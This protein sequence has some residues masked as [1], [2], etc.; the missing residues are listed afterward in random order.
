M[1]RT[2]TR[3]VWLVAAILI[4][5][6]IALA[7]PYRY[8]V[9]EMPVTGT[10]NGSGAYSVNRDGSVVGYMWEGSLGRA[11]VWNPISNNSHVGTQSM[12]NQVG[13]GTMSAASS[14]SSNAK[15]AG[16]A[17]DASGQWFLTTWDKAT[18]N[19]SPLVPIV[20]SS[21]HALGINNAGQITYNSAGSPYVYDNGTSIL[22]SCSW[23]GNAAINQAGDVVGGSNNGLLGSYQ[24]TFWEA[25]NYGVSNNVGMLFGGGFVDSGGL[26]AINDQRRTTGYVV[27]DGKTRAYYWDVWVGSPTFILPPSVYSSGW[28]LNDQGDVVGSY[29][30]PQ[31]H[32]GKPFLFEDGVFIDLQS[33]IDPL[34]G[35]YLQEAFDINEFGQICGF[36]YLNGRPRGY[37]LT[38]IPTNQPP[39]ATNDFYGVDQLGTLNEPAPGILVNDSDPENDGLTVEL[40]AGPSHASS[41]Q[42][43]ANGSFTYTPTATFFGTDTYT[44]RVFDGTTYSDPATVTITVRQPGAQGFIT[45]GGKFFQ[46]GNKCTFGFVAKVQGNGVQGNLEFQDHGMGLNVKS[47]S[48]GWVYAPN[49][50]DG[51]FSGTCSVNGTPGYSYFVQIRDRGEPGRNDDLSV[52]LFDAA[53]VQVYSSSGT[54]S[55]GGNIQIHGS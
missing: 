40:L 1:R 20:V 51:Y 29:Q 53:G 36:G 49:L 4:P 17:R 25:G 34:S 50:I 12:L 48:V 52:W 43:N 8:Y 24:G 5:A 18:G 14:I 22:L 23:G 32:Y 16:Y 39:L 11:F 3:H 31:G 38:P 13:G 6:S 19:P 42:Q 37:L 35:W 54:L 28:G 2:I 26:H 9:T 10:Y 46:S 7:Q 41:F 27:E 15:I 55:G 21:G 30:N 33:E 47:D 44:Y 45:G